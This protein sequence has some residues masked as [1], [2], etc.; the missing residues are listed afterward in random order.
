MEGFRSFVKGPL[1]KALLVLF[2]IPFAVIGVESYFTGSN[3]QNVSQMVNGE[4]ISKDELDAQIKAIRANYLQQVGG[5]ESLLNQDVIEKTAL[6]N[7]ILRRLI[8]QQTNKL[9]IMLSQAQIEQLLTTIAGFQE[10][11]VFSPAKYEAYLKANHLTSQ[12][13][14][15]SVRQDRAIEMLLTSLGMS[16]INQHDIQ[17]VNNLAN[18]QRQ[19]Y[20]ASVPFAEYLNQVTATDG[21]IQSYYEQHKNQ[22][23]QLPKVNVEYLHLPVG[24]VKV[25][26]DVTD[27]DIQQAYQQ[28]QQNLPKTV[29]HI[30]ITT[31]A[32]SEDEAKKRADEAYAK[33]QAGST[34]AQ[35]ATEYSEDIESKAKGGLIT[36]YAQGQFSDSF[37][38][39]VKN[40]TI[41]QTSAPVK[42]NFG[43]HII[44]VDSQQP[45]TLESMKEQLTA[46]VK[47]QKSETAFVELVNRLNE[48][49]VSTDSLEVIQQEVKSATIEK[50]TDI[51]PKNKHP[52]LGQLAVKNRL[53]GADVKQG[54]RHVSGNI[55]LANGDQVWV[56]VTQYSPAGVPA[57]EQVREQVKAKVLEEKAMQMAKA[58]IQPVLDGFKSKPAQEVL[59]QSSI[60]F[61]NAGVWGRERQFPVG[62][63]ALS[64]APPQA[65]H[66]S[67]GTTIFDN[68]LLVV[69]VADVKHEM[70]Q[71]VALQGQYAQQ[72]MQTRVNQE[73]NDYT[74]Y[75]KSIAKIK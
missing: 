8:V 2:T 49:V 66:W 56:K 63:V 18:E 40:V 69:A 44:A 32:R 50:V 21:E 67:V 42:T 14:V 9:G 70:S 15:N 35:V 36:G 6:N 62:Q 16:L 1:G 5:D 39:A 59:A 30:L 52:I 22:F 43:Y 10:N 17:Q 34:F 71:N 4:P 57:L 7:L 38:Q 41:G 72:Y 58:K 54:D 75:L 47:K 13:F 28:Y 45:A 61:E 23:V 31:D 12:E 26:A 60:K 27:A 24:L 11:G 51:S 64:L 37:D 20:V 3:S 53:F 25:E 46:Q 74:H 68:E 55:A 48:S 19:V 65:G 33:L 73:I 29:R